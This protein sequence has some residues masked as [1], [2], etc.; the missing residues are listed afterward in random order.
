MSSL[1]FVFHCYKLNEY[2]LELF[3]SGS[4]NEW[5][6]LISYYVRFSPN[7]SKYL[8]DEVLFKYPNRFQ[9]Y[10]ID[11]TSAEVQKNQ[12]LINNFYL[13]ICENRFVAHLVEYL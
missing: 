6:E 3:F 8:I 13:I 10:L 5:N 9:E 12:F 7:V 11:C 4:A 1:V 2:I